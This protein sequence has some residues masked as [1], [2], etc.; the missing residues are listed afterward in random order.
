M[1]ARRPPPPGMS[2][3]SPASITVGIRLAPRQRDALRTEADRRGLD[4][5]AVVRDAL[6]SV[7]AGWPTAS[8]R[9][10]FRFSR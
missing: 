10:R 8:A 9:N 2:P 4:M 7:I 3:T 1:T 6:A 5:S